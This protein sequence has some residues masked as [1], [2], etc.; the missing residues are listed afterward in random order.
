MKVIAQNEQDIDPTVPSSG[1]G[2]GECLASEAALRLSRIP[3]RRPLERRSLHRR[4]SPPDA[5]DGDD[6]QIAP[7]YRF[8]EYCSHA[9]L[10]A[11]PLG[12]ALNEPARC[13]PFGGP[14]PVYLAPRPRATTVDEN[15]PMNRERTDEPQNV[16]DDPEFLA[17]YSELERFRQEWGAAYEHGEFT[18]LLSDAA[19]LRVLDLGCGAGQLALHLAEAGAR[20]VIGLDVSERMLEVARAHRGHPRITYLQQSI[21]GADFPPD[22]FDLVVSSLALHYVEDY[23]GLVR[24]IGAWLVSGGILVFSTEHPIFAARASDDGWVRDAHGEPQAW[25]IDQYGVEGAR[26]HHWFREGVV[27]YHRTVSTLLNGLI[28][29]GLVVERVVEP[30]PEDEMLR[31][32]PEWTHERKRPT[33]LLVRARKPD[34]SR[35]R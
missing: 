17:G 35:S 5:G 15:R 7:R 26:E 1:D 11:D 23:G 31:H 27:K 8:T 18:S 4:G 34:R 29:A 12:E 20:E 10:L 25:T 14:A 6:G 19:A 16:Y 33:F 3:A 21:E 22:R 28:D 32:H 2:C 30:A 9:R 13:G 24:R